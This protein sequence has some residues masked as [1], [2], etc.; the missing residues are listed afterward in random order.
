MIKLYH[1]T[2]TRFEIVDLQ[3]CKSHKDFGNGF[4][5]T[6][7]YNQAKSWAMEVAE[8]SGQT[9]GYTNM[10]KIDP[11]RFKDF[12]VHKFNGASRTWLKYIIS[13]RFDVDDESFSDISK[14]DI[15]IGKVADARANIIIASAIREY[16]LRKCLQDTN[17]QDQLIIALK[18]ERLCDQYCFKTQNSLSLLNTF[19]ADGHPDVSIKEI[20]RK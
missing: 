1:G 15:V 2:D 10:Y 14:C 18:P 3:H 16:S 6:S 17:I 9:V 20:K 11:E 7:D 5:L 4:Y 19:D 12:K 8:N 13:N